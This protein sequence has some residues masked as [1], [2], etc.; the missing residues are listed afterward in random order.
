[1][2][3]I[4][5]ASFLLEAAGKKAGVFGG[6]ERLLDGKPEFCVPQSALA[7]L[8][9]IAAGRGKKAGAASAA[10]KIIVERKIRVEKTSDAR[11]DEA[12]LELTQKNP[13]SVVCTNDYG[14]RRRLGK[15]ARLACVT[16]DGRIAWC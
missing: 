3:V 16:R 9:S 7:E 12:I 6:V 5:D 14:L 13:G 4:L 11:A 15:S 2:K 1:M 8:K 10:V